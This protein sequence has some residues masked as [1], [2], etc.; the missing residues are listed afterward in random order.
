MSSGQR[1]QEIREFKILATEFLLRSM[2]RRAD[3]VECNVQNEV[4]K[5]AHSLDKETLD[6]LYRKHGSDAS[7]FWLRRVI[8]SRHDGEAFQNFAA[9]L[10]KC[11][12]HGA[13]TEGSPL[14]PPAEG[15]KLSEAEV[16]ELRDLVLAAV[17][18]DPRIEAFSLACEG[19]DF[20]YQHASPGQSYLI[21]ME[22]MMLLD[23][24]RDSMPFDNEQH[25]L[26]GLGESEQLRS[27]AAQYVDEDSDPIVV[28]DEESSS[29][30]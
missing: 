18:M 30:H 28:S 11:S 9:A 29:D 25:F 13:E 8:W 12:C 16:Q 6:G 23:E 21:F 15:R 22:A 19:L 20:V 7:R 4:S 14:R 27:F 5:I 3:S 2:D 26:K 10:E 24:K 17:M 1:A